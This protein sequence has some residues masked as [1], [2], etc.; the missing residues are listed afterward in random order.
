MGAAVA[1][2]AAAAILALPRTRSAAQEPAKAAAPAPPA[3]PEPERCVACHRK[4]VE[5]WRTS[6]H[7]HALRRA[8]RETLLIPVPSASEVSSWPHRVEVSEK[9]GGLSVRCLDSDGQWGDYPLPLVMGGLERQRYV[10]LLPPDGRP[11][12]LPFEYSKRLSRFIPFWAPIAAGASLPVPPGDPLFWHGRQENFMAACYRCHSPRTRLDY[13]ADRGAY[14]VDW[15]AAADL[16]VTCA[17]CHGDSSGHAAA[18]EKGAAEPPPPP[19]DPRPVRGHEPE[20]E[21]CSQCHVTGEWISGSYEAGE[22]FYD[23]FMPIVF[24]GGG[25]FWPDGRFREEAYSYIA[26]EMSRCSIEGHMRCG[27]CHD[28]HGDGGPEGSRTLSQ[29]ACLRC[30]GEKFR[31]KTCRAHPALPRHES[32][33][34]CLPCHMPD[35]SF[36]HGHGKLTDHRVPVPDPTMTR[37]FGE[38]NACQV[39]HRDKAP[40]WM[41]EALGKWG[42]PDRPSRARALAIAA[43]QRGEAGATEG[44][45]AL[46]AEKHAPWPQAATAARLLGRFPTPLTA[47]ALA[48]SLRGGSH[49][50]V[51]TASAFG[52]AT[53]RDPVG[54]FPGVLDALRRGAKDRLRVVR[55]M[56]AASLIVL[57]DPADLPGATAEVQRVV[58]EIPD[59]V[60]M[61]K[62]LAHAYERG[63]DEV[64]ARREWGR[65][66]NLLP[67]DLSAVE[68][69]VAFE[70]RSLF[71][72][73][74]R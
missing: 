63:G 3:T 69:A 8:T 27:D 24:D 39:C 16:G 49:P 70:E 62:L 50:M 65:V 51:R 4:E 64:K 5:R 7:A 43:G 1:T 29:A 74:G 58:A 15:G 37:L 17:A 22:P 23:A 31:G 61:R 47:Q 26:H 53:Q 34:S 60:D 52:L 55:L 40:E 48:D 21:A 38:P 25:Q 56:A 35:L 13:D 10:T 73:R 44:L 72:G 45:R 66:L 12:S 33:G 42:A 9:A 57:G 6:G 30:H 68:L 46:L 19:H 67:R 18:A 11:Q 54:P 14:R 28:S 32:P 71:S 36:A 20:I 59:Y 2:A 41:E